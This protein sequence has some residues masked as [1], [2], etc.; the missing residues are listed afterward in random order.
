MNPLAKAFIG[1]LIMIATVALVVYDYYHN[2]GL[3]LLPAI[4]T[5]I[6]GTVPPL[7]FMFG[8]FLFWLEI[9]EWKIERELEKELQQQTEQEQKPKKRGRKKKQ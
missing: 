2:L 7:V 8:L 4:I 9:D 5:V 3:G 6:K 1:I